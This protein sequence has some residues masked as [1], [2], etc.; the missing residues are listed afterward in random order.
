MRLA[1]LLALVIF[2]ACKQGLNE[3]CQLRSDCADGL[4]CVITTGSCIMGGLCQV[5][6]ATQVRCTTGAECQPGLACQTSTQCY[7][8]GA[9]VCTAAADLA[10]AVPDLAVSDGSH[11]D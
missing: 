10:V 8:E 11:S 2:A 4:T 3:R 5:P 1:P 9:R 7:D 6:T